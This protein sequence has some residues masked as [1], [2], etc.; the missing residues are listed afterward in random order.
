MAE[1]KRPEHEGAE[2]SGSAQSDAEAAKH[3][4]PMQTGW[5]HGKPKDDGKK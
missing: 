1:E 5:A 2:Q 3:P 4:H